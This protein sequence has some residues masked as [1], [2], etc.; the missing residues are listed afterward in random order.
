M[1]VSGCFPRLSEGPREED[2]DDDDKD[3]VQEPFLVAFNS[4]DLI[5][6]FAKLNVA[7]GK[8]GAKGSKTW[9]RPPPIKKRPLKKK[10]KRLKVVL[11]PSKLTVKTAAVSPRSGDEDSK[12]SEVDKRFKDFSDACCKE[13]ESIEKSQKV[14]AAEDKKVL[15][16]RKTSAS[17]AQQARIQE[18]SSVEDVNNAIDMLADYLEESVLLPKKMSYMAELMYT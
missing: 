2:D 10:K 17:C 12:D 5:S 16:R 18:Y 6:Q 7:G 15:K 4:K 11:R 9:W 3:C 1:A 8:S 13:L 14:A